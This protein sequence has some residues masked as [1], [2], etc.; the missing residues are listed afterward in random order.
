[1]NQD[2]EMPLKTNPVLP[3]LKLTRFGLSLAV[4]FSA[5]AGFFIQSHILNLEMIFLFS[6]V[7]LLAGSASAL[8]QFQERKQDG[9]MER[10]M[11]RPIPS[12]KIKPASAVIISIILGLTGFIILYAGTK[13]LTAILG[14]FNLAWYNAVYTP[15]KKR[16]RYA[17]PAGALTGA[18]PPMMGWTASGGHLLEPGILIIA[19]FMYCWQIPH[20]LLLLLKYGREYETAGFPPLI[21][22]SDEKHLRAVLFLWL[23]ITSAVSLA[24]PLFGIISGLPG[25]LI[26]ALLNG[27]FILYFLINFIIRKNPVRMNPAFNIIYLFQ[28]FILLLMMIKF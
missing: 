6:G 21:K 8:N 12:G 1:L 20:F 10:T 25:I 28:I 7:L 5:L 19:V 24:L 18:I 17:L 3:F 26:L 4:A 13:P 15:L 2:K 11:A 16:T 9:M 14:L 27:F 22:I 23:A